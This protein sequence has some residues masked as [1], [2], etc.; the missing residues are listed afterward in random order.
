[1]KSKWKEEDAKELLLRREANSKT[2]NYDEVFSPKFNSKMDSL[3][4]ELRSKEKDYNYEKN[5]KSKHK[6]VPFLRRSLPFV[7]AVL[8]VFSIAIGPDRAFAIGNRIYTA[9]IE[10][11]DSYTSFTWVLD[12]SSNTYDTAKSFEIELSKIPEGFTITESSHHGNLSIL[13]YENKSSYI[14]IR[15][16]FAEGYVGAV[17]SEDAEYKVYDLKG[18]EV[19]EYR[20]NNVIT[21]IWEVDGIVITVN[22]NLE[23]KQTREIIEKIEVKYER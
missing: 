20:K 9:I 5:G 22:S 21:A 2:L 3:F 11:L 14:R 13:S 12:E 7:A 10:V 16:Y 1:M 23:S 17:D 19:H 15:G 8:L 4:L 6:T 18:S